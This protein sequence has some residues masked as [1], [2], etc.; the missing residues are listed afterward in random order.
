MPQA[1]PKARPSVELVKV[2]K[3][4]IPD[5]VALQNVSLSVAR[6]EMLFCTGRSGAGKS[7]LLKL[8]CCLEAPTKG[9][10][11]VAG[12]DLSRLNAAE[13]QLLRQQIGVAYQDFKLLPRLSVFKNVAMAMEV[14]YRK[15]RD[16]K[17]RVMDLLEI[18]QVARLHDKQAGKL[19]RGE[20]QRVALA[21]AAAN[22]PSLLLADEPTGN[23]DPAGSEL[24]MQLFEQLRRE[25]A[26]IIVA[27]HDRGLLAETEHRVLNLHQGRLTERLPVTEKTGPW[28]ASLPWAE[29]GDPSRENKKDRSLWSQGGR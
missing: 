4:Y 28:Q 22:F 17:Q 27:T 6:G 19:S 26:T 21:R 13:I 25:G 8:I 9:I 2:T 24:V 3:V 16:I 23:L 5:V 29:G 20:Q 1:N 12:H 11:E 7:S 15:P 10:V 18:L 14:A